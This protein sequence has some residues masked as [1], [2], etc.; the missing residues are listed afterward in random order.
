M[1][2]P[3]DLA[4]WRRAQRAELLARRMALVP[5][6]RL[7]HQT[8]ITE[9]LLTH[10][11]PKAGTVVA[12]Y[13]P[14]KGEF[15]P[16]HVV[17]HWRNCG[18]RTVLPVVVEK[19][20]PLQFREWWPGVATVPGV[21]NLPVPQGTE[22]LIPDLLLMPPVGF[23]AQCFR[24]GY[25]GG[26]YDRTLAELAG[27]QVLCIGIAFELSRID[28]IFPQPHDIAMDVVVTEAGIHHRRN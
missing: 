20:H 1:A 16:R 11:T 9:T 17:R 10:F 12:L 18:V 21:F 23:D 15:E 2:P 25:G 13:W 19:A 22:L 7:R 14:F 27:H 24:L 8:V 26:Y 6:Q 3:D 28:T 5:E 4:G